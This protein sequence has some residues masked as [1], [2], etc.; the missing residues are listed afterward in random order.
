MQDGVVPRG[1]LGYALQQIGK[2]LFAEQSGIGALS[3]FSLAPFM[4]QVLKKFF[5]QRLHRGACCSEPLAGE[6]LKSIQIFRLS[7]GNHIRGQRRR[8]PSGMDLQYL[9]TD[10]LTGSRTLIDSSPNHK[11]TVTGLADN[12]VLNIDRYGLYN[13]GVP[14]NSVSYPVWLNPINYALNTGYTTALGA[15]TTMPWLPSRT[16]VG[17][18]PWAST[19]RRSA[20]R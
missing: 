2:F 16:R 20:R 4:A 12:A 10:N 11:Y 15:F 8:T 6:P 7:A 17:S 5:N 3:V 1:K 18:S 19:C 9:F 13:F 14:V